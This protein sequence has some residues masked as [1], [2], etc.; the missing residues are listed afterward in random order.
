[1]KNSPHILLTNDDGIESP[2]LKSLFECLSSQA[3]ISIV[4]PESQKSASGLGITLRDPLHVQKFSSYKNTDAWSVNGTPAD[5]I[6][7]ALSSLLESPPDMV[8]SGIN[9]GSN[10]GRNVL[11]SGT[12][13]GVIEGVYHGIS[14]IAISCESRTQPNLHVASKYIPSIV[15]Y[16]LESPLPDG[17]LLNVTI[18]KNCRDTVKGFKLCKQ[19]RSFW[20]EDTQKRSHPEGHFY[21]WLSGKMAHFEEDEDSDVEFLKKGYLTA[22]P[23]F[24]NDLTQYQIIKERREDFEQI[25][26]KYMSKI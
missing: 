17:V 10:S 15:K 9:H 3:K 18:P 4:A 16:T 19:G 22:V 7:I 23:I 2:G 25:N 24:V 5:C 14:G 13:A 6:K 12:V 1:M 11:Y 8:V 20:M 26:K 21:Y